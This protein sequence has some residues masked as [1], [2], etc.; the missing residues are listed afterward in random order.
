M[1]AKAK[2]LYVLP[3]I[4]W[5]W[6]SIRCPYCGFIHCWTRPSIQFATCLLLIL[7]WLVFAGKIHPVHAE[8]K[9]VSLTIDAAP[10]AFERSS[11]L[12]QAGTIPPTPMPTVTSTPTPTP[13]PIPKTGVIWNQVGSGVYFWETPGQGLLAQFPNGTVVRFLDEWQPYGG[14]AWTYVAFNAQTGWVD[15]TKIL[16]LAIPESGLTLIA[17]KG[18]YLYTQPQG[19][20]ITWL[21]PGTPVQL[22]ADPQP[23]AQQGWI[24]VTLPDQQSGWLQQTLLQTIFAESPSPF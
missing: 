1:Y 17:G 16:R 23:I 19:Q 14:L 8:Q 21:T 22:R 13:L 2:K 6:F 4:R 3:A 12:L 15:A 10:H 7:L 24:Q 5:K 11:P 9:E 20:K 18:G